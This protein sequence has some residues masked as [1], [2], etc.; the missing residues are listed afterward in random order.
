MSRIQ[1]RTG[2]LLKCKRSGCGQTYYAPPSRARRNELSGGGYCSS[3]CAYADRQGER[4]ICPMCGERN[5]R[6]PSIYCC[7][8]HYHA[9]RH[10]QMK[11]EKINVSRG[12]HSEA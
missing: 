8:E 6:R 5:V 4:Y 2:P 11:R 7:L 12:H 1:T 10:N 3:D 9:D